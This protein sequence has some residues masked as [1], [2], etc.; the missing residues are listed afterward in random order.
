MV[1]A[2]LKNLFYLL[3]ILVVL[4]AG[5]IWLDYLGVVESGRYLS[6]I[7]DWFNVPV[8]ATAAVSDGAAPLD[9]LRID[10]QL[11][12]VDLQRGELETRRIELEQLT[13]E[14]QQ[15]QEQLARL[16]AELE[17]REKTFNERQ[18][19]YDNKEDS[20]RQSAQFFANM[21]P[22]DAVERLQQLEDQDL[23]AILRMTEQLAQEAGA[24]ST[25][26]YWMSLMEPQRV[27]QINRKM[28]Q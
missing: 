23:I 9:Q 20:L 27:A 17:D 12:A 15:Q 18:N 2:I 7:Y 4:V 8:A 5:I 16:Q 24:A 1:R 14:I 26:P 21:P 10:K 3:L 25:V 6:L 19:R 13:L 22:A 28:L 11:Q